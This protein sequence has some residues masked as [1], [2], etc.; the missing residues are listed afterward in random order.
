L[1]EMIDTGDWKKKNSKNNFGDRET[2]TC[3]SCDQIQIDEEKN[4]SRSPCRVFNTSKIV[5]CSHSVRDCL[6]LFKHLRQHF[7]FV[8][9]H[10]ALKYIMQRIVYFN[11]TAMA[12]N[13]NT[14][15]SY[16]SC[17]NFL[18]YLAVEVIIS[19]PHAGPSKNARPT[20]EK[21]LQ[22]R[23]WFS[24]VMDPPRDSVQ[25]CVGE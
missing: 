1:G 19:K 2:H 9:Q 17:R 14:L 15:G 5:I 4:K 13:S 8:S 12:Q 11:L 22:F 18:F 16:G 25:L 7:W 6:H 24:S 23:R 3:L 10:L 20:S 21:L